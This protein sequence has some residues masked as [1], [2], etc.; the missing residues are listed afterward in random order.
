MATVQELAAMVDGVLA[1]DGDRVV[2]ALN[3]LERAGS[4]EITFLADHKLAA[5]AASCRAAALITSPSLAEQITLPASL[6]M[7]LVADPYLAATRIQNFLLTTPFVATGVRPGAL[8]GEDCVI[9]AEVSVAPG[10]V[11]GHRVRLGRRVRLEAGVVVGDDTVIGDDVVLHANVTVYPRSVI[12]NRVIVHG[13]SVLGSDG[14]GYATDQQGNHHK[15]LH[16]GIVRLEDDV[17]IGANCCIDRGTFGETLI[18]SGTKIDNLVQIGHNVVVGEN[19]LIVAQAGIAGSTMLERQVV[20]SGQ[21]ALA[22]HLRIGSGAMVAAKSGVHSDLEPGAVVSG[23]PAIDHK[24]WLR[25]SIAFGK[26]PDL[27]RE[28]REL[29]RQVAALTSTEASNNK[30]GKESG[31]E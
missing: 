26:L 29:R 24:K 17:E 1:G 2:T 13:G 23:M 9:P 10:V 3:D 7:I 19:T 6:A 20:L 8:V 16:L 22:G 25:A 31:D 5:K 21:V 14:F 12:G 15:R 18:R 28:V 11:L 27:V 4:E 30:S